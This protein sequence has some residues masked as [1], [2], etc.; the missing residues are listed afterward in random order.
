M[1]RFRSAQLADHAR[2]ARRGLLAACV[3]SLML[4]VAAE[5]PLEEII[6]TATPLR[7]TAAQTAQPVQVIAGDAWLLERE[8]SLGD[9]L[10]NQPGVSAS[11]FGPV[12]SRPL[13]RGQ[14][15]L[16]VQMFQDGADVLDVAALSDD[17][18][19]DRKSVV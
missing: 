2:H 14:G 10:A 15:G 3:A 18:A 6:V 11:S 9:S 5:T 8:S 16:R 1:P 13:L 4:P 17:H 12:A 19:V 7:T